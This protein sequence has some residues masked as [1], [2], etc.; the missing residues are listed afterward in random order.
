MIATENS[1]LAERMALLSSESAFEMGARARQLAAQ[2]RDMIYLQIGEPDFDTPAHV[3][4]AGVAAMRGGATHYAPP[5][6]VPEFRQSI[7]SYVGR[8]RGVEVTPAEVVVVP[9][10]KPV[11]FYTIMMLVGPGDEVVVPDPGFPAYASVTRFAGATPVPLTLTEKTGFRFSL[12]ELRAKITPRTRLLIINSP[13]NPTGAVLTAD[14]MAAIAEL[15]VRHNFWVLSDEIYARIVYDAPHVSLMSFPA[16]RERLVLLDGFSKSYAMTGWRLGYGVM[17]PALASQ[18]ELLLINSNSCTATFTQ[19][20]GLAALDGPQDAVE[21]MVVEFKARRDLMIAGLNSIK[22]VSCM[23]PPGAFYVF[24][25]ISSFGR[26]SKE[27][28]DYLLQ[29]AGVALLSGAGFGTAGEGYLRISYANSQ[30]NLERALE[31]MERA[32]NRL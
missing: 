4:E 9:G 5:A 7:A 15:A 8:T 22:G 16:V 31:R 6:G 10:A 17:P 12:D 14:D 28:A 30:L 1:R 23:V 27:I 29:E 3:I 11:I 24:P 13:H 19:L 18:M 20:A 2:G 32:F 26:S 25:N 21:A